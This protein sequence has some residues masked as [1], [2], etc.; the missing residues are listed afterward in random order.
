MTKEEAQRQELL[1]FI[2]WKMI[3]EEYQQWY[4]EIKDLNLMALTRW[5]IR[6]DIIDA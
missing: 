1:S 6:H 2:K 4:P 5:A 3:S